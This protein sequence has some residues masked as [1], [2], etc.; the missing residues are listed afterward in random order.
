MSPHYVV[1]LK[2]HK[3]SRSLIVCKF[4]TKSFNVCFEKLLSILLENSFSSL[5]AEKS[6]NCHRFYEH[7]SIHVSNGT[8]F[9]EINQETRELQ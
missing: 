5:L 1:K 9:V 3:N 8:K 2:Q 4:N 6:L 7:L